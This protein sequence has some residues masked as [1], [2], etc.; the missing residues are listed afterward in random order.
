MQ[1][2]PAKLFGHLLQSSLAH[3]VIVRHYL[4]FKLIK[5]INQSANCCAHALARV[6]AAVIMT[7]T[8]SQLFITF[9]EWVTVIKWILIDFSLYKC[10]W[11][12]TRLIDLV[13]KYNRIE[14]F[15]THAEYT[16]LYYWRRHSG[17]SG[18]TS[19]GTWN[20]RHTAARRTEPADRY[21]VPGRCMQ[22]SRRGHAADTEQSTLVLHAYSY[23]HIY[24]LR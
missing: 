7:L 1:R 3:T 18:W 23:L 13:F 8:G 10:Y 16:D 22:S 2:Q 4:T 15:F 19:T 14:D 17:H 11:Y 6:M 9:N 12:R 21:R 20:V 24:V 5:K